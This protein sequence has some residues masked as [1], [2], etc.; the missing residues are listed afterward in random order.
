M[1]TISLQNKIQTVQIKFHRVALN[2]LTNMSALLLNIKSFFH[3]HRAKL[4][5]LDQFLNAQ[6]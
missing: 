3:Q 1:N 2:V 6:I 5:R 4:K